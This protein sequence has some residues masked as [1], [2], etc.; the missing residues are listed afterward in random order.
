[1]ELRQL[2]YFE[3][4]ARHR[5]FT[6]AAGA[7]HVAQS[8][9]S[10]QVRRLETELG[11]ELLVRG[12]RGVALTDAGEAVL[13]RAARV[14]AEVDALR[15]DVE[16]LTGLVRGRVRL[17]AME[18]MGPVDLP[19]LLADFHARHPAVGIHVREGT[20]A[21]MLAGLQR[22]ELDA[23][24]LSARAATLPAGLDAVDLGA[25]E[26]VVIVAPGDALAAA[27]AVPLAALAQRPFV[28]FHPGSALREA[29]DLA[30]AAAGAAPVVAFESYDLG[31]VR[32]LVA[33]G[34]G[35][36]VVPR[37]LLAAAGA[38]VVARPVAPAPLARPLVLA[39]RSGRRRAA[40]AEAFLAFARERA[41]AP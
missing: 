27:P 38:E 23:A 25:E 33:R 12:G 5:H 36:S 2:R 32:A 34:L 6:N 9:L 8:A 3:A 10:H 4:V 15:A 29:V 40:A 41:P 7:L 18:V 13:T 24:Y 37:S 35:A 14:L 20:A 26:L 39:W 19:A 11:V 30:L 17:G 21:G 28:A 1:M 16:E 31:T 22:D